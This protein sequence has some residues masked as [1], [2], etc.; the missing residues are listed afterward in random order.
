MQNSLF[1]KL[2][3]LNLLMILITI[4]ILENIL[5]QNFVVPIIVKC[6]Y[7]HGKSLICIKINFDTIDETLE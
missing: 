2:L 7:L 5:N 3:S 6:I 4:L 1:N